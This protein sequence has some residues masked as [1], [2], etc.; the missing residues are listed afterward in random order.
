MKASDGSGRDFLGIRQVG[1]LI[2]L[3][4]GYPD[5]WAFLCFSGMSQALNIFGDLLLVQAGCS[6]T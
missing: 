5:F 6:F 3:Q 4:V 2:F 1:Y